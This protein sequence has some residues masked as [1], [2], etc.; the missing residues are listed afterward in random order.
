MLECKKR[1]PNC[2]NTPCSGTRSAFGWE[3]GLPKPQLLFFILLQLQVL[4]FNRL[5]F[6]VLNSAC[7]SL[8]VRHH[9]LK[10][11]GYCAGGAKFDSFV[12]IVNRCVVEGR[13][14]C[15]A[16]NALVA[17]WM[18]QPWHTHWSL[19]GRHVVYIFRVVVAGV[20]HAHLSGVKTPFN[21]LASHNNTSLLG[22]A[23]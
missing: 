22:F 3:P 2:V 11:E 6:S 15:G 8:R 4:Y 7:K 16:D 5:P 13:G 20:G 23:I 21:E 17:G 9:V 10:E 19:C 14:R 12:G 18:G 1:N